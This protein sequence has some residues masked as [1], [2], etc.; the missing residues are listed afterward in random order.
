MVRALPPATLLASWTSTSKP[1]SLSPWAADMAPTPP[2]ST[3][4]RLP[5]VRQ[6]HE[7]GTWNDARLA[8]GRPGAVGEL[9]LPCHVMRVELEVEREN[10]MTSV[11]YEQRLAPGPAGGSTAAP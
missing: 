6:Y 2:P 5:M 11:A 8:I 7:A 9:E 3:T 10:A 1:R 4:T